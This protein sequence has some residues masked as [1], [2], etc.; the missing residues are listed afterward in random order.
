[1]P[2]AYRWPS[3][4]PQ[5]YVQPACSKPHTNFAEARGFCLDPK[6]LSR[7]SLWSRPVAR[8]LSVEGFKDGYGVCGGVAGA[9]ADAFNECCVGA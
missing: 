9:R 7:R 8:Q 5:T 4:G 1:M 2:L 6:A 3:Q